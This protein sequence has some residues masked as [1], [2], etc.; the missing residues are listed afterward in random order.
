MTDNKHWLFLENL[1]RS[2]ITNMYGAAPYLADAFDLEHKEAVSI[3]V[4][5]MQS[6]NPNDY[7]EIE[8]VLVC[9]ICGKPM[10]EGYYIMGTYYCSPECLHKDYSDEEYTKLYDADEAYWTEWEE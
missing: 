8:S 2:G 7:K 6:Y 10:K 3:L 9:D 1:R 4:E 5:W